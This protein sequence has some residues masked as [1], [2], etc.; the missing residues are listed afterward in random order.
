MK[1]NSIFLYQK[2]NQETNPELELVEYIKGGPL[3]YRLPNRHSTPRRSRPV[4]IS[5]L[6]QEPLLS[7]KSLLLPQPI[8]SIL[9]QSRYMRERNIIVD[10]N[11]LTI[12]ET[13]CC[14]TLSPSLAPHPLLRVALHPRLC[15]SY[16]PFSSPSRPT[17]A[18]SING[19]FRVVFG[20]S[21]W[22]VVWDDVH[23]IS[24]L[25]QHKR[26]CTSILGPHVIGAIYAWPGFVSACPSVGS[27]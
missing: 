11:Y 8:I 1:N 26:N 10:S 4:D 27:V 17:L 3:N 15:N 6:E 24:V 20:G 13:S 22:Y 12:P 2:Q 7:L 14:V 19:C 18:T 16:Y 21:A 9:P 23:L 5:G 25:H